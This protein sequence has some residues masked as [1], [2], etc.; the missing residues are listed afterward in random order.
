MADDLLKA[1]GKALETEI[2]TDAIYGYLASSYPDKELR[3][4]FSGMMRMEKTHIAFWSDFLTRHGG[5]R[6]R[7]K[8]NGFRLVFYKIMLRVLGKE[9]TL[10][11]MEISENQAIELYSMLIEYP[12]LSGAEK[13]GLSHVLEDELVHEKL[14]VNEETRY[15]GI[16]ANIKD[17]VLGLSDGLVEILAATTGLA[18][19]SGRPGLVATTGLVVGIAGALSMGISTFASS[20]SQRQVS[21]GIIKRISLASKFAGSIYR[22][23]L[24]GH[25]EKRGYSPKLAANVAEESARDSRML[26]NFLEIGRASCRER[27][28]TVV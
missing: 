1:A 8:P 15:K 20:R 25:L 12:G 6:V 2:F 14:L 24:A 7:L 13:Q 27:V 5:S 28:Y 10:R 4:A 26:S 18:A 9:L 17:S 23:R 22:D 16:I 21:E 11:L 3:E 19:A